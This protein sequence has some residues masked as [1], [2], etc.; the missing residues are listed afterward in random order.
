MCARPSR[1]GGCCVSRVRVAVPW[2]ATPVLYPCSCCTRCTRCPPPASAALVL[3][4]PPRCRC[5]PPRPDRRPPFSTCGLRAA[6]AASHSPSSPSSPGS[7]GS[8]PQPAL[9]SPVLSSPRL[10]STLPSVSIT[11][12]RCLLNATTL[13]ATL[14]RTTPTSRPRDLET[15]PST[16]IVHFQSAEHTSGLT[17]TNTTHPHPHPSTHLHLT[18]AI[19]W[20]ALAA[21]DRPLL[22]VVVVCPLI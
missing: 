22:P 19:L 11:P 13:W 4:V 3:R 20:G 12:G 16:Y 8:P 14:L 10:P 6:C 5:R 9:I 21:P 18:L 2:L 15:S 17:S 1:R 7:P